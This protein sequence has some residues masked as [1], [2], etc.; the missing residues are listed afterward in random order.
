MKIPVWLVKIPPS[1][2]YVNFHFCQR[3]YVKIP[4][5]WW[6]SQFD[7]LK[8][9][10]LPFKN[11]I[12][13]SETICY[14]KSRL[15]VA[16]WIPSWWLAHLSRFKSSFHFRVVSHGF[17]LVKTSVLWIFAGK[18][19]FPMDF[20]WWNQFPMDFCWWKP[21]I[22]PKRFRGSETRSR[23]EWLKSMSLWYQRRRPPAMAIGKAPVLVARDGSPWKNKGISWEMVGFFGMRKLCFNQQKL[24]FNQQKWCFKQQKWCFN[25]HEF[26]KIGI[27]CWFPG[28][29]CHKVVKKEALTIK[30]EGKN[31][32]CEDLTSSE[33]T[34]PISPR[35]WWLQW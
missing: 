11:S 9:D 21:S 22:F 23:A 12:S 19:Q 18:K 25:Q 28:L 27:S 13:V 17:L 8:S 5:C 20:C 16:K 14:T 6:K 7:W 32:S 24:C 35:K 15:S 31:S 4:V 34:A 26:T 3:N 33:A 2:T 10:L 30:N 29:R 1:I